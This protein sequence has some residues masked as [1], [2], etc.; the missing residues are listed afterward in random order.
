MI[1]FTEQFQAQAKAVYYNSPIPTRITRVKLVA[2]LIFR[3]VGKIFGLG[4]K[5]VRTRRDVVQRNRA[6]ET[7]HNNLFANLS[8]EQITAFRK[9]KCDSL[10]LDESPCFPI[11]KFD[12]SL[13]NMRQT[14]RSLC[15]LVL[16]ISVDQ[17]LK[18]SIL[19]FQSRSADVWS[20]SL[21]Y[22]ANF[23]IDYGNT[24]NHL[25]LAQFNRLNPDVEHLITWLLHDVK[26]I[27]PLVDRVFADVSRLGTTDKATIAIALNYLKG[28]TDKLPDNMGTMKEVV[29]GSILKILFDRKIEEFVGYFKN[30]LGNNLFTVTKR[31]LYDTTQQLSDRLTGRIAEVTE[32]T[33]FKEVIDGIVCAVLDHVDI[34]VAAEIAKGN[35]LEQIAEWKRC[36]DQPEIYATGNLKTSEKWMEK[37]NKVGEEAY[38]EGDYRIA[39][40]EKQNTHI[41]IRKILADPH[42]VN[43]EKNQFFKECAETILSVLLPKANTIHTPFYKFEQDAFN[44]LRLV[45]PSEIEQV[46]KIGMEL[47]SQVLLPSTKSLITGILQPMLDFME[48]KSFSEMARSLAVKNLQEIFFKVFDLITKPSFIRFIAAEHL[49]PII[50]SKLIHAVVIQTISINRAT[51]LPEFKLLMNAEADHKPAIREAIKGKLEQTLRNY[52]FKQFTP[53]PTDDL[54][55]HIESGLNSLET[56]LTGKD[57]AQFET[58]F[59]NYFDKSDPANEA[60]YA[61]LFKKLVIDLGEL[62]N[63]EATGWFDSKALYFTPSVIGYVKSSVGSILVGILA[64]FRKDHREVVDLIVKEVGDVYLNHEEMKSVILGTPKVSY[65]SY[66]QITKL[67]FEPPEEWVPCDLML[68]HLLYA[69]VKPQLDMWL[70]QH[71]SSFPEE[72]IRITKEIVNSNKAP[73]VSFQNRF[74]YLLEEN[75]IKFSDDQKNSLR[76]LLTKQAPLTTIETRNISLHLLSHLTLEETQAIRQLSKTKPG[77]LPPDY[78]NALNQLVM[79]ELL[80]TEEKKIVIALCL[81]CLPHDESVHPILDKLEGINKDVLLALI[82]TGRNTLP[83]KVVVQRLDVEI[84]RVSQLAHD[85]LSRNFESKRGGSVLAPLAKLFIGSDFRRINGVIKKILGKTLKEQYQIENLVY[86]ILQ[87]VIIKNLSLEIKT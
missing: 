46:K 59:D 62:E 23:I 18:T 24:L 32:K 22:F 74:Q 9:A 11:V 79:A 14:S 83:D 47:A 67:L 42:S 8:P 51:L 80:S 77:K 66:L 87:N 52:A 81:N 6:R 48:S 85:L 26:E 31:L 53:L 69:D 2:L 10:K 64:D 13:E 57:P 19:N 28:D 16:D 34:L 29:Y 43:I 58:D 1:I 7:T 33:H 20:I 61:E 68:R 38:A 21:K 4:P 71:G 54:K 75:S 36:I 5:V 73:L 35:T 76:T 37:V 84:A 55:T 25:K 3:K 60:I 27:D 17:Y 56:Y 49:F 30:L 78:M 40:S 50:S 65:T 45:I 63:S 15:E 86:T 41:V 39:F 72:F 12:E 82:E 70:N 44:Q